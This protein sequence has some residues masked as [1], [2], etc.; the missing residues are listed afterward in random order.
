[1]RKLIVACIL[2]FSALL[3]TCFFLLPAAAQ[4]ASF[5]KP[6]NNLALAEPTVKQL[7]PLMPTNNDGK[8]SKQ[9]Y[10]TFL[11]AEFDRLDSQ[12]AGQLDVAAL[13]RQNQPNSAF[14]GK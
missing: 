10:M 8:L 13:T 2:L 3:V 4:K 1:M 7:L 11:E 14:L 5:P 6:Q 12:R 9:Q